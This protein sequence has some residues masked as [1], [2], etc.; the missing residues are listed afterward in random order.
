MPR[1]TVIATLLMSI[2]GLG[3]VGCGNSSGR[4]AAGTHQPPAP[5]PQ[6][7]HIDG[8]YK[9]VVTLATKLSSA[10]PG[11]SIGQIEIGDQKLYFAYLPD[12][13]FV[14][15]VQPDGSVHATSGPSLLDGSLTGGRLIF[16]VRTYV[17]SSV[18][19]MHRVL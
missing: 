19:D 8:S 6:P 18:Y 11:S 1:P 12:T 9:G 7:Q 17:C 10:C 3:L 16:S 4:V 13:L 2:C 15:P 14:A 5:T